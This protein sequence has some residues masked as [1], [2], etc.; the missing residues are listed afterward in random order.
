MN[1]YALLSLID[2]RIVGIY[3]NVDLAKAAVPAANW[4][5]DIFSGA[6]SV[7]YSFAE[8][9]ILEY[10]VIGEITSPKVDVNFGNKSD[11][12]GEIDPSINTLPLGATLL[13]FVQNF[14]PHLV[15][16]RNEEMSETVYKVRWYLNR[17]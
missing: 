14:S 17:K 5:R 12:K 16:E 3:G 8:Y 13:G 1:V 2:H 15:A 7:E 4:R 11:K 9:R 6:W 10:E